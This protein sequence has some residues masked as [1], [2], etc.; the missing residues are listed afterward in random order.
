MTD[1]SSN[2]RRNEQNFE[3]KLQSH[4]SVK[5]G[6][7]RVG[8]LHCWIKV[9]IL[10]LEDDDS[11]S[12]KSRRRESSDPRLEIKCPRECNG[13]RINQGGISLHVGWELRVS[14]EK[15]NKKTLK[16]QG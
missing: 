1:F 11:T 4:N 3:E 14:R 15:K 5:N 10:C 2:Y 8:V 6:I 9:T 7:V 13:N 12:P 16:V